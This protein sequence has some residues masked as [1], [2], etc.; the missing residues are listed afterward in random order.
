MLEAIMILGAL[1][2]P[3]YMI[4]SWNNEDPK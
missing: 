4:W 3:I 2:L 1:A